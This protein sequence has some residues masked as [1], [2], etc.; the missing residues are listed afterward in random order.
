MTKTY[1]TLAEIS[2][3]LG[4]EKSYTRKVILK[5]GFKPLK[6]REEE[7]RNQ[8]TLALNVKDANLLFHLRER[9]GFKLKYTWGN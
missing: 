1:L 3:I 2:K 8:L 7:T 5:Y 9:D 6:V 4:L